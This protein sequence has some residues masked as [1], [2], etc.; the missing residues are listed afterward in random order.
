MTADRDTTRVV[1]SWLRT[2]EHESADRVLETVLSRLD[3]TP[4]RRRMLP[5]RR[6]AQM[7]TQLKLLIAAAAVVVVA[8]VGYQ[9]LPRTGSVGG[10][11]P[12]AP[13]TPTPVAT[14]AP[15]A[16]TAGPTATLPAIP[17]A[18]ALAIGRHPLTL[19]GVPFTFE[20]AHTGWVSNG[21][22]GFD[23]EPI[24]GATGASF[25]YWEHDADGVFTDPCGDVEAP[26]VGRSAAAIAAAIAAIPGIELVAGPTAVTIGG[27]PAQYVAIRIPDVIAC[28]PNHFYLWYDSSLPDNARYATD[29]GSTIRVWIIEV[30]GKRVQLDGET[31]KGAGPEI[32]DELQAIIDSITFG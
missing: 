26:P 24:P 27:K 28:A 1:R 29:T 15:Q 3:T 21:A 2:D 22:F 23:K 18:G 11:P 13:P 20:I 10:Q 17:P 16:P 14:P 32:G 4:Q 6:L 19:E 25:I 30:D 12:T 8:V 9:L 7:N 31:Y 5:S